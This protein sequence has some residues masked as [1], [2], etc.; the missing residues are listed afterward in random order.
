MVLPDL[1]SKLLQKQ[2][3]TLHLMGEQEPC[4]QAVEKAASVKD[5]MAQLI[6]K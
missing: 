2:A 5:G 4:E 1:Q 3:W 6:R